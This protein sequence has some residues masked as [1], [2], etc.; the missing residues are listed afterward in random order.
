MSFYSCNKIYSFISRVNS[1]KFH[2]N[3][4]YFLVYVEIIGC[5]PKLLIALSGYENND[6][7]NKMLKNYKLNILNKFSN[8]EPWNE[9]A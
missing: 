1:F 7:K 5:T 8:E 4:F 6:F 2:T 9:Y 3:D